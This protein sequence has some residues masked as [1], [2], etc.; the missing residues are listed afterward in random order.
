MTDI[1]YTADSI[2]DDALDSLYALADQLRRDCQSYADL[3]SGAE[4]TRQ[5][6]KEDA[7]RYEDELRSQLTSAEEGITAAIRQR[8]QAEE[9]ATRAEAAIERAKKLATRWVVLR[10]YGS[11][12]TELR[13]ALAS[14]AEE[15]G[16]DQ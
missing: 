6:H 14:A 7:D 4:R 11:A 15:Q 16:E 2:T 3:A 12:A 1:R 5:F 9:R 13:A 10:A 8:K